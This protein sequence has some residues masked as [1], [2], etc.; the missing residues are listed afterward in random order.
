MGIKELL[1]DKYREGMSLSEVEELLSGMELVDKKTLPKTVEKS[2]FDKT[3]SELAK[4]KKENKDIKQSSMTAEEQL[5][6]SLEEAEATKAEYAKKI[7][8]LKAEKIFVEAG[9]KEEEYAE[10]TGIVVSEDVEE[11]QKR[12][13]SFVNLILKQKEDTEAKVKA[14]LT[15]STP[16]PPAPGDNHNNQ[17]SIDEQIKKAQE[18]G[19][20]TLLAALMRE[21][22]S[23]DANGKE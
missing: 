19:D 7:S 11:T 15:K 21:K 20:T 2:V 14:D 17:N 12:A 8:T 9:L 5:K 10:L 18:V 23:I 1:G 4:L 22:A 13:T 6:A 16:K 3:A